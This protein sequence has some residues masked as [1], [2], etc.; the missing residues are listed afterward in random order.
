MQSGATICH[1]PAVQCIT[2]LLLLLLPIM[3]LPVVV[4][5]VVVFIVTAGVFKRSIAFVSI[6][7][8]LATAGDK[9]AR[10]RQLAFSLDYALKFAFWELKRA[11]DKSRVKIRR[12]FNMFLRTAKV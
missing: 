4:G 3:I 8:L 1:L 11:T 9:F 2:I 5:T 7:K 6:R 10:R 12:E